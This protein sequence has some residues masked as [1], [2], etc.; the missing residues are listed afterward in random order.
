MITHER[1]LEGAT[2]EAL[3]E[4]YLENVGPLAEVAVLRHVDTKVDMLRQFANPRIQKIVAW[5]ANEP[6]GLAMVT[7]S[8]EDVS[9]ISPQFL[10]NRFPEHAARDAIY[11]GMLVMVSKKLRGLTVFNRLYTEL[12]QV[13]AQAAGVLVYD[14]CEF[15]RTMFDVDALSER[16]ASVFPRS[17][18]E[19]LDR[20]TWFVADLPE[21]ITA[22]NPPPNSRNGIPRGI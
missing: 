1:V 9:E 10:R 8:L 4:S 21:P 3:Y 2:A 5:Q 15:N 11:I 12:W 18:V 16:I 20:Q 17:S 13:P 14:V 7:N 22:P 19:L 6:V